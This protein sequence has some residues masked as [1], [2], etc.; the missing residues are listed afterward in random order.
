MAK[1]ALGKPPSRPGNRLLAGL[2]RGVMRRLEQLLEPVKLNVRTVLYE[3]G[4]PVQYVYFVDDG[5]CSVVMTA[6]QSTV[7]VATVGREGFVGTPL[8]L[9][10]DR[11]PATAFCQVPGEARRMPAAAFKREV[12]RN[13]ALT[14]M[15]YRYIEV[16]MIQMAQAAACNR[17][18][19]IEKRAA[20]WLLMTHDRV[21][22]DT[23]PLTQ[24]FLAQMLG[25]RRAGV[26]VAMGILQK[27]GLVEYARGVVTIVD[28][29]G[30][31]QASCECYR[32]IRKETDRL[33]GK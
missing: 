23:F 31:E 11:T 6:G 1:K 32:V 25:V 27:A 30:L 22:A 21:T 9:G 5:V 2:P 12:K 4:E 19:T 29:A 8:L 15:L 17:I 26:N 3:A 28:R 33:V 20:R 24:E 13:G 16:V 7:E 10:S 18:H 14:V